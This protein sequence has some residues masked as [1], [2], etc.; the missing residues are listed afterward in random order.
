MIGNDAAEIKPTVENVVDVPELRVTRSMA[1][2]CR[3]LNERARGS[4]LWNFER[5][6]L[7]SRER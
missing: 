7:L 5:S 3:L 6:D 1:L 4:Q 2:S